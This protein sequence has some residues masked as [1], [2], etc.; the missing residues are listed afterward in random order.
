MRFVPRTVLLSA[1]LAVLLLPAAAGAKNPSAPPDFTPDPASVQR[2]GPAYRYPQAGWIVLHV[3]G[4]PYERGYQHGKLLAPE[5]ADHVRSLATYRSPKA[6]AEAW[7][8]VRLL[9]NALFLRRYDKEYLEEMKG[10]ADGAAAA[11]ARFEG[12]ALDLLDVVCLNSS[13]EIDFLEAN[14][15]ATATGLEGMKFKE[16]QYPRLR[17]MPESHC[18]AFAA[19]GPATAD[20]HVVLGHITMWNLYHVRHY[21]VWL[22]LKPRDGHRVLMQTFPGGIMSGL[23]YYM[24]DAG[25]LVAETTIDQTKFDV[26]GA[27]MVSRIRKALQYGS[28]ID[29][30][31]AILA[32]DCNGVYTNEWLLADT[33]TDE[34]A[35]FELGT[36]KSKLWRSS[37]DEWLGGTRGFYWGCNNARDLTVRLETVA[38]VEGKPANMVFAPSDRDLAWQRLY[39]KHKGKIG[40]AFGFEAFTT[41]PLAG[42][43]SCDAKFTTAALAK[44]LKS[45][46]LFGPPMGHTWEPS[47]A[48]RTRW[49][50]IRPLVRNDWALLSAKAPAA[51]GSTPAAA[52]L[53]KAT[54][55]EPCKAEEAET[56][57]PAWHGTV[58]AKADG[59]V[60]LAAAFADYERIV[61]LEKG[62]LGH[63]GALADLAS[64]QERLDVALY[65]PRSRYLTAVKR[66]GK[67]VPLSE[68]HSA[69]DSNDWCELAAGK[70]VLLLAELRRTLGA[71]AFDKMMDDFGRAHA[72]KEV[73]TAEFREQAEKACGR[74]L[75]S[76]FDAW[77]TA[78]GS[79]QLPAGGC[80]SIFSFEREPERA[81]IVYGTLKE[82]DAQREAAQLLQRKIARRWYNYDVPVKAD[83]EV[84]DDDLKDRHL[85]LVGRPDSNA[86]AARAAKG[87][88]VTFG[89][90]SFTVGGRTYAHQGSAVIAAGRHPL[91]PRYQVVLYAGLG[92]EATLHCVQRLPDDQGSSPATEV[93]LMPAGEAP[94]AVVASAS[95]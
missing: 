86:V 30:A 31:V 3:E 21:N 74:S 45:W 60:W 29:E 35:M 43:P 9:I 70:G 41:P 62:L 67:D 32:K 68:V 55:W 84:T 54:A 80:W 27:S 66:L 52:D 13:I 37:R 75:A 22:D 87:L 92:A 40:A 1:G 49:P 89:S 59:D 18:S 63:A 94:K 10:I 20:G 79:P 44:E 91:S 15:E 38:S 90:G 48:D 36:H 6:P 51:N 7:R 16:P 28:S 8:D 19:T 81:L 17:K 77:L 50:D 58:L 69:G 64:V 85:L 46:N 83:T 14:L 24:N 78:P 47:P 56:L 11:G 65:R 5:I 95:K 57:P 71:D 4:A 88:P 39:H 73:T 53:G 26:T 2:E 12:R 34:I 25:L 93:L 42:F 76:V 82:K 72:G 33:K 61:A 23:D